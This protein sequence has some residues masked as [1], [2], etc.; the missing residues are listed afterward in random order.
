MRKIM[1]VEV[2]IDELVHMIAHKCNYC[3]YEPARCSKGG[4]EEGIKDYLMT[5]D[6]VK[7]CLPDLFETPCYELVIEKKD[8]SD[9]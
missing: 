4:C 3:E 9:V 6:E 8:N 5:T 2:S 7:V 1:T